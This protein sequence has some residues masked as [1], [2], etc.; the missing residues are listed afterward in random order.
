MEEAS[1]RLCGRSEAG[2]NA[3]MQQPS[4]FGSPDPRPG[5]IQHAVANHLNARTPPRALRSQ[6]RVGRFQ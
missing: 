5:L 4:G 6:A 1:Q 3:G 2:T